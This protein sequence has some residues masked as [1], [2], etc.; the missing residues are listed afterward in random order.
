MLEVAN[1]GGMHAQLA[2]LEFQPAGAALPRKVLDGLV[3][4]VLPGQTMRWP[5]KAPA[6]QFANGVLR[7]RINS[8]PDKTPLLPASAL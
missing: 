3:G 6:S 7:A 2:D 5:L 4:Y 8:A 1:R